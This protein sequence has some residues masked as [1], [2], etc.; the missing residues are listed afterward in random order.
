MEPSGEDV[1]EISPTPNK[2]HMQV[3]QVGEIGSIFRHLLRESRKKLR[4]ACTGKYTINSTATLAGCMNGLAMLKGVPHCP[5]SYTLS[6][7]YTRQVGSRESLIMEFNTTNAVP[8][9][10]SEA[11]TSGLGIAHESFGPMEWL[12]TQHV[13]KHQCLLEFHWPKWPSQEL[14]N[15]K[16]LQATVNWL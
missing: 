3:P 8:T 12:V 11:H 1:A 4:W 10:S 2:R 14:P 9:S 16:V 7:P 15:F 13:M 6:R 5:T